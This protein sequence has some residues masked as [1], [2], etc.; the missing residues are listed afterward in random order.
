RWVAMHPAASGE[1]RQAT[2]ALER[3]GQ[4]LSTKERLQTID[5]MN[6]AGRGADALVEIERLA[7]RAD[8]PPSQLLRAQAVALYSARDYELAAKAFQDAAQSSGGRE[9]D[10]LF[11]AARALA[12]ADHDDDAI[13]VYKDVATRWP[14]TFFGERATYHAARLMLQNGRFKEA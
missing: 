12:R 10:Q 11:Y 14:K 4:P 13:T 2:E 6:E 9:P 5:A 1:A 3:L 7:R 8:A